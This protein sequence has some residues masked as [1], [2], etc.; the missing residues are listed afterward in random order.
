MSESFLAFILKEG[1]I[2]HRRKSSNTTVTEGFSADLIRSSHRVHLRLVWD[3]GR[4]DQ[5]GPFPLLEADHY[6]TATFT[7]QAASRE[8]EGMPQA[9]LRLSATARTIREAALLPL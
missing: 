2:S 5:V 1:N 9:G 7:V 6:H 4:I 3:V 8:F